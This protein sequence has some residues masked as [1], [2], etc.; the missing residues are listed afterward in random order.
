[1]FT[2]CCF[3]PFKE[4]DS[5]TLQLTPLPNARLW[6]FKTAAVCS[7]S[8]VCVSLLFVRTVWAFLTLF[9]GL[10]FFDWGCKGKDFLAHPPNFFL[11]F[12][13][14]FFLHF[15]LPVNPGKEL[16][17]VSFR[18]TFLLPIRWKRTAK[19]RGVF[20]YF[21]TL[22]RCFCNLLESVKNWCLMT[23]SYWM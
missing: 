5:L 11:S 10:P 17:L 20:F 21:Q 1:M 9:G 16:L 6:T 18:L 12:W 19:I 13:R 15:T 7:I 4:L 23:R 2:Y 3:H 14:P 8:F 22:F